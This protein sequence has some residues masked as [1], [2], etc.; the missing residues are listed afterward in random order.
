[1]TT[2]N[3]GVTTTQSLQGDIIDIVHKQLL[4]VEVVITQL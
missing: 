4:A 1:M 3:T 2:Y